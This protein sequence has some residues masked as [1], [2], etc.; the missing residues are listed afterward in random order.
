MAQNGL[1]LLEIKHIS[2]GCM[3]HKIYDYW[4]II[5][6]LN[7]SYLSKI[8]LYIMLIALSALSIDIIVPIYDTLITDLDIGEGRGIELVIVV[9]LVGMFFGELIFGLGVDILG[10]KKS[11]VL[12]IVV[13]CIGSIVCILSNSFWM[14]NFGRFLQG[15]GIAAPK[16]GTRALVRDQFEG[17]QLASV[18]SLLLISFMVL[19]LIA[20]M[21]GYYIN[22][23]WGWEYIFIFLI[24]VAI[25][26][27]L[28]LHYR[29]DECYSANA[30]EFSMNKIFQGAIN[31]VSNLKTM[32]FTIVAGLVFGSYIS[33]IALSPLMF[34]MKFGIT[35]YFYIYFSIL[36]VL[37]GISALLNSKL[38]T[39][40]G[41]ERICCVSI[42]VGIGSFL[43]AALFFEYGNFIGFLL[44]I[45]VSI[46]CCGFVFGN[47]QALAME[48]L[49]NIA[50]FGNALVS[51]IST[52]VAIVLA[53]VASQLFSIHPTFPFAFFS[54]IFL[55]AW[56]LL[57][58][59]INLKSV[60]I[61]YASTRALPVEQE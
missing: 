42:M 33:F 25:V 20:P 6:R 60:V 44:S 52:F 35:R 32:L 61:S 21:L 51:S 31:F 10:R 36:T 14:L 16:I 46:S 5:L 19:P 57:V 15:L 43:S 12:G 28:V 11:I 58:K 49:K 9:F 4:V 55:C 54:V 1:F 48:Q 23:L 47:I 18:F 38:V 3:P 53:I 29:H 45:A 13:F 37:V 56:F 2:F 8:T 17:N 59:A 27:T 30:H 26:P 22:K 50:G 39:E 40:V 41:A 24:A 7:M 34:E